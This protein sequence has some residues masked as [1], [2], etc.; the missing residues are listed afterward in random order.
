MN[1]SILDWGLGLVKTTKEMFCVPTDLTKGHVVVISSE[2]GSGKSWFAKKHPWKQ[3][4]GMSFVHHE[5]SAMDATS[6]HAAT[7][8]CFPTKK[9]MVAFTRYENHTKLMI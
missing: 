7:I 2:S 6:E 4:D 9:A 5:L 1:G 3:L 8:K